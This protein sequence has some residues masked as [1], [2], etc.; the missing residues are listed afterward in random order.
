MDDLLSENV[1]N[2]DVVENCSYLYEK[3]HQERGG[4]AIDL[5]RETLPFK[6]NRSLKLLSLACS[7]GVIEERMQKELSLTVTGVDA[8]KTALKEARKRG[9]TI[10]CADVTKPLPFADR[11]YDYVFAGEVIEHILDTKSFL[12]EMHRVLKPGGFLVITTPNLARF[13][14]RLK[15]LCGK[16]PRQ[17]SPLHPYLY[18]HIRPFTSESLTHA[19][20]SCDFSHVA[21]RTNAFT[22]EFFGKETTLYSKILRRLFPTFG[23]TLIV[24]AQKMNVFHSEEVV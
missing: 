1:R 18:L 23:T 10:K 22:L 13:D 17:T 15:L 7:I 12:N 16:T 4:V 20:V 2:F 21:V 11:S 8:A 5:L 14:D 24:R 3:E 19:L 9:L 6:H